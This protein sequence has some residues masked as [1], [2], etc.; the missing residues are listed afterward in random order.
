MAVHIRPMD[1]N[2]IQ[3]D[4]DSHDLVLLLQ[5]RRSYASGS[6]PLSLGSVLRRAAEYESN[7]LIS[8]ITHPAVGQWLSVW[9]ILCALIWLPSRKQSQRQLCCTLAGD[10]LMVVPPARPS[11]DDPT[12]RDY[13]AESTLSCKKIA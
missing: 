6:A 10:I 11:D 2:I 8:Q 5:Q 3:P 4:T 12:F 13:E 1:G 7:C 9:T